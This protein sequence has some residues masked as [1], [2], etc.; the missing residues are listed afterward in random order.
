MSSHNKFLQP[1]VVPVS[2]IKY[3]LRVYLF[4]VLGSFVGIWMSDM[5]FWFQTVSSLLLLF[6]IWHFIF[7]W[8][9]NLPV[10]ISLMPDNCWW[11]LTSA[12]EQPV[13]CVVD[14]QYVHNKMVI[15]KL[16]YLNQI[17]YAVLLQ[18]NTHKDDFRRLKVR[19]RHL[20]PSN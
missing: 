16:S 9:L 10:E 14:S 2:G 19:I 20:L 18:N 15:L 6:W 7:K 4:I 5:P 3:L 13:S 12:N 11:V 17:S 8:F 1:I